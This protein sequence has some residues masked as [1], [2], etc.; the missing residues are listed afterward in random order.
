MDGTVF[1]LSNDTQAELQ[2][3]VH[4]GQIWPWFRKRLEEREAALGLSIYACDFKVLH[5]P[6]AE[7]N[8]AMEVGPSLHCLY[9]TKV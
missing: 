1:S 5:L 6:L 9:I 2:K 8:A 4:F 3:V 7:R